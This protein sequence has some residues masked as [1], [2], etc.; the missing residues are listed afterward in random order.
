MEQQASDDAEKPP[1]T[2]MEEEGFNDGASVLEDATISQE[3]YEEIQAKTMWEMTDDVNDG[4]QTLLF[5]TNKQAELLAQPDNIGK[6]L[7]H[8]SEFNKQPKLQRRDSLAHNSE[9]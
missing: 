1:P 3:R 6:L 2:L 7:T 5:L 9:S 4:K 8:G